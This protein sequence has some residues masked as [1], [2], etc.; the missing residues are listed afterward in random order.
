MINRTTPRSIDRRLWGLA[1]VAG[2]ASYLD[3]GVIVTVGLSLATWKESFGIDPLTLGVIS[4]ALT[5]S[6]A[7]G[8]LF[9]GRIADLLG[10]RRVFNIDI[11]LYVIG[12]VLIAFAQGPVMIVTGVVIAGLA[13]G[14]DLPTS[15]AVVS[16]LAPEQARGRLVAFTQVMWSAGAVVVTALGFAVSDRGLFGIRMLFVHLAVLGAITWTIRVFSSNLR[17]LEARAVQN[18]DSSDP[19]VD[20][21]HAFPLR[22]LFSNRR[23]LCTIAL[24]GGFYLAWNLMANTIGQFKAYLLVTVSDTSQAVATGLSFGASILAMLSGIVFVRIADTRFRRPMFYVGACL[25][26]VAMAIGAVTGGAVLAAMIALLAIYMLFNPF[27]GEA[28]YKVTTQEGFP[29]NARATVQ[30]LTYSVSR[31]ACAGFAVVTPTIANSNPAALLWILVGFATVAAIIGSQMIRR[32]A[33]RPEAES[34]NGRDAVT[35][36]S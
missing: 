7:I 3:A 9:G 28:L 30:G 23:F 34:T 5:F 11:F 8:A 10:R 4:G 29:V 17:E 33:Y 14:A 20:S 1:V 13:A 12:I 6:I 15:V 26:I 31:F 36:A 25:Q 2:M 16:E 22:S 27:A 32:P 35:S 21:D 18:T 24:T 19:T